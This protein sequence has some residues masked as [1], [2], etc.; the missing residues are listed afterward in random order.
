MVHF[1]RCYLSGEHGPGVQSVTGVSGHTLL[2]ASDSKPENPIDQVSNSIPPGFV[3]VEDLRVLFLGAGLTCSTV[4]SLLNRIGVT[5]SYPLDF[6]SFLF[7]LPL[8]V[9]AHEHII[10]NPLHIS[11]VI[12]GSAGIEKCTKPPC[13]SALWRQF[14]SILGSGP[15]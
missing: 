1:N 15:V 9:K 7:H 5:S 4:E 6:T 14:N 11:T 2:S 8:F 13:D 10:Q 12:G 3:L